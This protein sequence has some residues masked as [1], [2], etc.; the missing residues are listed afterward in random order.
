MGSEDETNRERF[1]HG[2]EAKKSGDFE[3]AKSDFESILETD[4]NIYFLAQ[5]EIALLEI[6]QNN[7]EKAKTI[8]SDLMNRSENH[9]TKN[10]SK[11]LLKDLNGSKWWWVD[12]FVVKSEG[13]NWTN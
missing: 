13:N 8:L 5:Y 6:E 11:K 2:I 1:Y 9:F 10:K 4:I 3:I 12:W 7:M